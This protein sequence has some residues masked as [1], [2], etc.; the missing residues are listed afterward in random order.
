MSVKQCC[1]SVKTAAVAEDGTTWVNMTLSDWSLSN[2]ALVVVFPP[3]VVFSRDPNAIAVGVAATSGPTSN[4]TEIPG[5]CTGELRT[6][7]FTCVGG[8]R[9]VAFAISGPSAAQGNKDASAISIGDVQCSVT[10]FCLSPTASDSALASMASSSTASDSSPS[11]SMGSS[12]LSGISNTLL[13]TAS[14][15]LFPPA[16]NPTSP[17]ASIETPQS[18]GESSNNSNNSNNSNTVALAVSLTAVATIVLCLLILLMHRK[19]EWFKGVLMKKATISQA[20]PS[21]NHWDHDGA[22]LPDDAEEGASSVSTDFLVASASYPGSYR[23][24][25]FLL[26]LPPVQQTQT[27][28][29]FTPTSPHPIFQPQQ[30]LDIRNSS[31]RSSFNNLPSNSYHNGAAL[32]VRHLSLDRNNQSRIGDPVG[33]NLTTRHQSLERPNHINRWTGPNGPTPFL[34]LPSSLVREGHEPSYAS[35]EGDD[36]HSDMDEVTS[37][38]EHQHRKLDNVAVQPQHRGSFGSKPL[39]DFATASPSAFAL[40]SSPSQALHEKLAHPTESA[41]QQGQKTPMLH[42]GPPLPHA[43]P[44]TPLAPGGLAPPSYTSALMFPPP[45][46]SGVVP[47]VA[48]AASSPSAGMHMPLM[49][50][51]VP[52]VPVAAVPADDGSRTVPQT[53][54]EAIEFALLQ[55]RMKKL[56]DRER[57]RRVVSYG[58]GGDSSTEGSEYD[59]ETNSSAEDGEDDEDDGDYLEDEDEEEA[60]MFLQQQLRMQHAAGAGFGFG[61]LMNF[62]PGTTRVVSPDG[63]TGAAN[64]A[65][66]SNG[67]VA[68][69]GD[70]FE[71]DG[72]DLPLAAMALRALQES[73]KQKQI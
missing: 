38:G 44:H 18:A 28:P 37:A 12:S 69:L 2:D 19:R 65:S 59:E 49:Q 30:A 46:M 68:G 29:S 13:P 62:V 7:R 25:P 11:A 34:H 47:G 20:A 64:A 17:V 53:S 9:R 32:S 73:M 8:L 21:N 35:G 55:R 24:G 56:A 67:G 45:L 40:P 60:L 66:A 31:T 6:G 52:P 43:S 16:L 14:R 63:F 70:R 42:A 39:L 58:Y 22:N 41:P 23:N 4:E 61:G 10:A 15:S 27:Y 57:R 51:P 26:H 71:T 36:L 33:H 1:V 50:M 5:V 3:T 72:D 48:L 54:N